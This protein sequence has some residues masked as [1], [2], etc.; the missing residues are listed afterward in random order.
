MNTAFI[1]LCLLITLCT[2]ITILNSG[3]CYPVRHTKP[4]LPNTIT[5]IM[6]KRNECSNNDDSDNEAIESSDDDTGEEDFS[7]DNSGI[8]SDNGE[9]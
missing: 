3:K 1:R 5:K 8:E 4:P 6:C 2:L 7:S 9:Y